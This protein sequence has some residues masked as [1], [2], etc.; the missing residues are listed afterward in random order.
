MLGKLLKYE[1]KSTARV[2]LPLYPVLLALALLNK[3]LFVV[4]ESSE[5]LFVP[6]ILS[7]MLYGIMIVAILVITFIVMI[8]RFYKNLLGEEGYL[9]FTLPVKASCQILSKLIVAVIWFLG[10]AIITML[11]IF[12]LLPNYDFI[13][14][15]PEFFS[16]AKFY[17][18]SAGLNYGLMILEA[19]ALIFV[20]LIASILMIYCAIAIGHL[21]N[22]HKV[23]TSLGAYLGIYTIIQAVNMISIQIISNNIFD[24]DFIPKA[25][26]LNSLVLL[27][28]GTMI[29]FSVGYF[30]VTKYI[31]SKKLNLQ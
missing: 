23:L 11:S 31:L 21:A 19:I 26:E 15:L 5:I 12:I 7:S 27:S 29:V 17:V 20:S 1:L 6:R 14:Q 25:S 4:F 8:Q 24:Q 2:F 13:K 22:K 3:L 28:M 16:K 10:S 18:E 30:F 9:M